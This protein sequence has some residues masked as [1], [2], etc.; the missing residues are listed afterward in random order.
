MWMTSN[1]FLP[2]ALDDRNP[3]GVQALG[4][5]GGSRLTVGARRRSCVFHVK[6]G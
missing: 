5:A 3:A 6:H 1:S 4:A 2:L